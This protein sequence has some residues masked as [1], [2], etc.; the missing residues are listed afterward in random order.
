MASVF[1]AEQM[2]SFAEREEAGTGVGGW[3]KEIRICNNTSG[4]QEEESL[5]EILK[6]C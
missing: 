4:E 2:K 1:S 3:K 6:N 5:K